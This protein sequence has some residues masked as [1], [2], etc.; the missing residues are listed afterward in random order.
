MVRAILSGHKTQTRRVAKLIDGLGGVKLL[1]LKAPHA[2]RLVE[3]IGPVWSPFAGAPD[4]PLPV[5][6]LT[7]P[8]G[9]P[10]D[11]LWVRET[12]TDVNLGGCPGL[13][14]R[15]DGALKDLMIEMD[16]HCP[17]GSFNYDDPRL[18]HLNFTAWHS[19][20]FGDEPDSR[21][22]WRPSIYMPKWA[23]RLWLRVTGVRVEM[24]QE[25][26]EVDAESEGISRCDGSCDGGCVGWHIGHDGKHNPHAKAAFLRLWN[27]IHLK[28]GP[29]WQ[30]WEANPWVWVIEF[31]KV[32]PQ[33]RAA[34][35]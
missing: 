9:Q 1:R 15:A 19:D 12:W 29:D 26:S 33:T 24:L 10:G 25:I 22:K 30:T 32:E 6:R 17:D 13:A 18:A 31:E 21:E 3:G 7:S 11:L 35:G 2:A 27:S 28:R 23:C 20:Q 8:Y 34:V 5:D 14:Y 16:C 4:E